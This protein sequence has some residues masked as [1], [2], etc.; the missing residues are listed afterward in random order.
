MMATAEQ[1]AQRRGCRAGV[2]YTIT[3]QAPGFY[4]KLGW[5]IFGEI[6]CDPPGTSRV[7]L[8]KTFG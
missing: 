8:T 2:L 6:A 3:F 5:R 1:E 4:Q 7:F